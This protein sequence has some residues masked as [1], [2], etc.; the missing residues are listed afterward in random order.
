MLH[1]WCCV[2]DGKGP[3]KARRDEANRKEKG[4]ERNAKRNEK[5]EDA[6][7]EKRKEEREQVRDDWNRTSAG[8]PARPAPAGAPIDGAATNLFQ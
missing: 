3:G 5:S 1:R 8:T 4:R 7:N 6:K 2:P